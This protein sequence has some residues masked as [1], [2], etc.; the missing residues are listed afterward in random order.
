MRFATVLFSVALLVALSQVGMAEL[1]INTN[2]TEPRESAA[3]VNSASSFFD[4][5]T[6]T[7][8]TAFVPNSIQVD[9][10]G[11]LVY[12]VGPPAVP[13]AEI[14]LNDGMYS[15]P[16]T[17]LATS[18]ITSP[19]APA[20]IP[21]ETYTFSGFAPSAL[22]PGTYYLGLH[23]LGGPG[24]ALFV[25]LASDPLVNTGTSGY[26]DDTQA[27]LWSL[28]ATPVPEPSTLALAACGSIALFA[29]ARRRRRTVGL[30]LT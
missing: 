16:G 14:Y 9:L 25:Q 11:G 13:I 7:G 4:R 12:G 17:L 24:T 1:I 29:L 23:N 15:G 10:V 19:N 6:I 28:D 2:T 3:Q 8:T 20:S 26:V 22:V 30:Q 21:Y 5:F 18:T 27:A